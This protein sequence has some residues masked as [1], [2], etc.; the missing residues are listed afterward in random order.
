MHVGG[1]HFAFG[2]QLRHKGWV[3]FLDQLVMNIAYALTKQSIIFHPHKMANVSKQVTHTRMQS[4]KS[5]C[6]PY[7]FETLHLPFSA[8]YML[9]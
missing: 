2:C 6:L 3:V 4:E 9:V 5:L 8:T 1:Q 7:G